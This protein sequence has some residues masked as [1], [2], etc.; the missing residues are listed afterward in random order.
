MFLNK[1]VYF[2]VLRIIL[3]LLYRVFIIILDLIFY[4][5][6]IGDLLLI[7]FG[8]KLVVFLFCIFNIFFL[9]LDM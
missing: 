8:V 4:V 7:N 2:Y 1:E 3:N 6:K 9:N 5:I